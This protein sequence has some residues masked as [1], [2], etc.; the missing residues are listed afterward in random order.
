MVAA[1]VVAAALVAAAVV[2]ATAAT[3]AAMYVW[4]LTRKQRKFGRREGLKAAAHSKRIRPERKGGT[5]PSTP[6]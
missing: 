1:A 6:A 3:A 5:L 2:A 4:E